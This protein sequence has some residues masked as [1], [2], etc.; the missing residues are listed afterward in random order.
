MKKS[1]RDEYFYA[2][3]HV[4]AIAE[5]YTL[6]EVTDEENKYQKVMEWTYTLKNMYEQKNLW[7]DAD[8]TKRK[9][10]PNVST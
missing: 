4:N 8:Q 6:L 7:Q 1:S 5:I 9:E 10:K 3:G 2:L